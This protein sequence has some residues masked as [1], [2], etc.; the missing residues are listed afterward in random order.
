MFFFFFSH[1]D[2]PRFEPDRELLLSRLP[3]EGVGLVMNVGADL[4]S[5]AASAQLAERYAHVYAAAGLHPDAVEEYGPDALKQLQSLLSKEKVKALGEIGLDY[6]YSPDNQEKQKQVFWGQLQ[7]A[8]Q[9]DKPV[10]VH[11]REAAADTLELLSRTTARGVVHCFTGSAETA[12][13][14]VKKGWYIGFTGVVTFRN[15]RKTV[16]AA[17]AVPLNRLLIETDCPYMAPEPYRGSRCDSRLLQFTCARL[18]LIKGMEPK[19]LEKI[20]YENA[21]QLYR[22]PLKQQTIE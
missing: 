8:E 19:E 22:I 1:Y 21:C 17:K 20:T 18:A 6:Y 7:L 13:E 14:L 12:K 4:S 15:A 16:E 5:S 10:I 9:L 2:D 3:Q 11:S